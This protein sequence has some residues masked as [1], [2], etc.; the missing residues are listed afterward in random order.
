MSELL[1]GKRLKTAA[2][3]RPAG[4]RDETYM[5][6]I[7]EFATKGE[8]ERAMLAILRCVDIHDDLIAVLEMAIEHIKGAGVSWA[9]KGISTAAIIAQVERTLT[10]AKGE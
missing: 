6:E 8:A 5:V 2:L 1:K 4:T 7:T 9:H 10:L 3:A